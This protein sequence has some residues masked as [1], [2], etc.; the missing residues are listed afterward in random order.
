M[1]AAWERIKKLDIPGVPAQQRFSLNGPAFY[2]SPNGD[3]ASEGS[4]VH[5]WRTLQQAAANLKPGTVIYLM[6]GTYY[7]PVEIQT[8]ASEKSPA[9]LR[10]LAGQEAVI[11]CEDAFVRQQQARIAKPGNEGAVG[12]DGKELHYPSLITLAASMPTPS[13]NGLPFPST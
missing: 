3:D 5:P 6:A 8:I 10:A 1:A 7:G 11:T 9:A 4:K 12:V 13:Q 2:V